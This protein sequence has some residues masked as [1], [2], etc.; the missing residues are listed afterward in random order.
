MTVITEPDIESNAEPEEE[1]ESEMA[2]PEAVNP[3]VAMPRWA[4]LTVL[5]FGAFYALIVC[6]SALNNVRESGDSMVWVALSKNKRIQKTMPSTVQNA[7]K[8]RL[9]ASECS[10]PSTPSKPRN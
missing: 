5:L 8:L 4:I 7:V 6:S 2:Q 10:K 9:F 1:D 3:F